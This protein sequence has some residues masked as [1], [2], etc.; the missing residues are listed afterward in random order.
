MSANKIT[1]D[2]ALAAIK[3]ARAEYLAAGTSTDPI[4]V[5]SGIDPAKQAQKTVIEYCDAVLKYGMSI[6]ARARKVEIAELNILAQKQVLT[7]QIEA[8]TARGSTLD[9]REKQLNTREQEL[10]AR[11]RAVNHAEEDLRSREGALEEALSDL[12]KRKLSLSQV[13][14]AEFSGLIE[15]Q[16]GVLDDLLTRLAQLTAKET[17]LTRR[18]QQLQHLQHQLKQRPE[19]GDSNQP[20]DIPMPYKKRRRKRR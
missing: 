15:Q 1:L 4:I 17:S 14:V 9:E 11:E 8:T 2:E 6:G 18:E 5:L 10:S 16:R 20:P 19:K 3:K 7:G 12:E 13:T